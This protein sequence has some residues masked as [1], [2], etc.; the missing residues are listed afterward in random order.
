MMSVMTGVVGDDRRCWQWIEF[1]W[2]L[3]SALVLHPQKYSP[4]FQKVDEGRQ[5]WVEE[6]RDDLRD[7]SSS[8]TS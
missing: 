6:D 2:T 7:T 3:A 4:V 5:S 8:R 1:K